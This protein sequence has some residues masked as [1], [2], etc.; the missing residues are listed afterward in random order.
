MT[1]Q[2]VTYSRDLGFSQWIRANLPDSKT[3]FMVTDLDFVVFNYKTKKLMF[4]EIKTRNSRP[5]EWQHQIFKNLHRW[6]KNGIDDDWTYLGYHLIQFENTNFKDGKVFFD[7]L[8][9]S[10]AELIKTLSL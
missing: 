10:E 7:Y 9:T 3:G 8:V 1:R 5:K 4:L 2:E 6:I